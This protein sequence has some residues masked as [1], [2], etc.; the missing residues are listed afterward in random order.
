MTFTICGGQVTARAAFG[1]DCGTDRT[2][3]GAFYVRR[4]RFIYRCRSGVEK[5]SAISVPSGFP[6]ASEA[7]SSACL[8]VA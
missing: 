4:S 5:P 2:R 7:C 6:E 8:F 3:N 1:G